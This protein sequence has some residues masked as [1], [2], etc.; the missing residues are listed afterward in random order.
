LFS[1]QVVV[2]SR[3]LQL[4]LMRVAALACSRFLPTYAWKSCRILFNTNNLAYRNPRNFHF[5]FRFA[6]RNHHF[7]MAP[8]KRLRKLDGGANCSRRI[9]VES[10]Y[11]LL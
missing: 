11:F 9:R 10:P 3:A 7:P 1:V 6:K 2:P 5:F 8:V 4:E